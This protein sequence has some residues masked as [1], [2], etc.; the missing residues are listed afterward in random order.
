MDFERF[1]LKAQEAMA[2]SV[3]L[4]K[5]YNHQAIL[6]EHVLFSLLEDPKGICQDIF[7]KLAIESK[8]LISKLKTYLEGVVT[9][10]HDQMVVI[11]NSD[12]VSEIPLQMIRSAK[13]KV[14]L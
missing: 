2:N 13:Q 3:S 9:D 12:S 7:K 11:K 4:V 8:D 5:R 1:T 6:P 10:A 14:V